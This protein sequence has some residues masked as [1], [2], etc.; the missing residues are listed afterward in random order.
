MK[1]LSI[2]KFSS[3]RRWTGQEPQSLAAKR[4]QFGFEFLYQLLTHRRAAVKSGRRLL[5]LPYVGARVGVGE[6]GFGVGGGSLAGERDYDEGVEVRSGRK[7]CKDA[8]GARDREA[9][10][11]NAN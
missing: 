1:P 2:G 3:K 5:Q 6:G 9:G 8:V 10:Q 11:G 7:G 4:L